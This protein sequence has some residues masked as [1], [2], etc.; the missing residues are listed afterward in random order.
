MKKVSVVRKLSTIEE[1][2]KTEAVC[3][4]EDITEAKATTPKKCP[5]IDSR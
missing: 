3:F 4:K 2:A 5:E 1:G